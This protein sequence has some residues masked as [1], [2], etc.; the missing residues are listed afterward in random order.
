MCIPCVDFSKWYESCEKSDLDALLIKFI[1]KQISSSLILV[2]S[3]NFCQF[4]ADTKDM[5]TNVS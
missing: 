5:P 4:M 1:I 3:R 2:H